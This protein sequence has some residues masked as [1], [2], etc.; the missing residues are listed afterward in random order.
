MT[1]INIFSEINDRET[2]ATEE[3][4]IFRN[5]IKILVLKM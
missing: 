4:F 5:E 2:F 3:R 1:V